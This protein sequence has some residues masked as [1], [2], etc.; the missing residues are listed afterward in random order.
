MRLSISKGGGVFRVGRKVCMCVSAGAF[1][2]SSGDA[3]VLGGGACI[4]LS[5]PLEAQDMPKSDI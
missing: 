1:K 2:R 3:F 4:H 5:Y